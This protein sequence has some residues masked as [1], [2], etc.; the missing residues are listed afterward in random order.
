MEK[1]LKS[2]A[3]NYG[4]YLGLILSAATIIAYTVNLELFT[5]WWYGI[6][7]LF[8]I[9]AFGIV[10]TSKA[11][12]ALQGF[13]SFKQAFSSFFI[14]VA[15]G[16]LIST[17]VT[18]VIFNFVDPEA[19]EIVKE[20]TIQAS[21]SMMENFGAPQETINQTVAEM[22]NTNQFGMASLAQSLAWQLLF[23]AVIGL[24]VGAIMKKKDPNAE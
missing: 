12:G 7:L 15:I 14:T 9:I 3:V 18:V 22:Q 13:I 23:Y 1:S 8:V 11:K 19:A 16:L 20:S 6:I 2:M 24:I 4:L 5:K 17:V 21:V 10:S